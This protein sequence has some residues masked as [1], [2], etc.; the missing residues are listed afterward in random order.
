M[1]FQYQS[2]EDQE[3]GRNAIHDRGS[4]GVSVAGSRHHEGKIRQG[5]GKRLCVRLFLMVLGLAEGLW[6]VLS[7]QCQLHADVGIFT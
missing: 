1:L 3:L 2:D 4:N 7:V 6:S 5:D